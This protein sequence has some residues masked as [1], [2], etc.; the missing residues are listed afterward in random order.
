MNGFSLSG[1]IVALSRWVARFALTNV[2]WFLLNIPTWF[3]VY[4]WYLSDNKIAI[5]HY[6]LFMVVFILIFFPTTRAMFMSIRYWMLEQ[7][8]KNKQTHYF[9]TLFK[10]YKSYLKTNVLFTVIWLIWLIDIYILSDVSEVLFI[11]FLGLGVF[12]FAF[13][14]IFFCMEAHLDMTMKDRLKYAAFTTVGS[15]VLSIFIL[16]VTGMIAYI[17]LF[18]FTA[19]IPFFSGVAI[20]YL[21]LLMFNHWTESVKNKAEQRK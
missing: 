20:A 10:Y 8:E 21:A 2:S 18:Q 9:R 12:I 11:V 6:V 16:F 4:S 3:L 13:Q 7:N 14:M 1:W 17:S 15:P 5:I 19:L